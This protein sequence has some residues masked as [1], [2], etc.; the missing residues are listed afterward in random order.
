MQPRSLDSH[1]QTPTAVL[2]CCKLLKI[3]AKQRP[4]SSSTENAK[5]MA[6]K[7]EHREEK[8]VRMLPAFWDSPWKL[9]PRLHGNPAAAASVTRG[10]GSVAAPPPPGL[11]QLPAGSHRG[12]PLT[13]PF[14]YLAVLPLCCLLVHPDNI[15]EPALLRRTQRGG[16]THRAGLGVSGRGLC[17][18]GPPLGRGLAA[19]GHP[20]PR[21]GRVSTQRKVFCAGRKL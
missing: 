12:H 14:L 19:P 13:S 16:R 8:A 3:P 11:Q 6:G 18:P 21:A 15:L 5:S 4:G 7:L 1:A 17:A 9:R 2:F 20:P 10:R